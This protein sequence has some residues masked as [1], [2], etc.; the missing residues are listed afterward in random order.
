[1]C[2]GSTQ[3]RR[4]TCNKK[5][6]ISIPEGS[7]VEPKLHRT[8]SSIHRSLT[9]SNTNYPSVTVIRFFAFESCCL[10]ALDLELKPGIPHARMTA[11]PPLRQPAS[12][13]AT[14]PA[15]QTAYPPAR[16]P[17]SQPGRQ[18]A[19]PASQPARQPASPPAR[20]PDRQP[21]RPPD[22]PSAHQTASMP[23]CQY[24]SPPNP[25]VW[26]LSFGDVRFGAFAWKCSFGIFRL[27]LSRP[28]L[29]GDCRRETFVWESSHEIFA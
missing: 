23:V 4:P 28:P 22:R 13:P 24:A 5:H 17:T 11:R 18:P 16:Q 10:G 1:M 9:P 26:K 27:T 8:Y 29:G 6:F 21:A 2:P 14:R 25:F 15:S 7:Q 12:P 20:Q 19:Q 3:K